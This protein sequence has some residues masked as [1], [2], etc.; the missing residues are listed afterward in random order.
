V[1]MRLMPRSGAAA[2]FASLLVASSAAAD[3]QTS[4]GLTVGGVSE[5]AFGAGSAQG[6]LH[7]G[8][9]AD[10]L[11]LRNRGTDMAIGPYVDLAT[12]SFRDLDLGGG[13]EWL[14]PIRD[15]LPL[16]LSAGPFWR[17]GEGRSWAPGLES[18]VFFGSRSYNFHSP[19]GL[20]IGVFTQT[21]WLPSSPGAADV[22]V[23][24]QIDGELLI[25]PDLLIL[26]WMRTS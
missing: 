6:A 17:N 23:G 20:A 19:Y 4:L 1:D 24:V 13:A 14:L 5:R 15:D 2:A 12:S 16:V 3:P 18:T 9:R 22:V 7:L 11:F 26:S 10:I 25:L 8:G 21:R